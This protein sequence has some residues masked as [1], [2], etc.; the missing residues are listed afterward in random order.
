M[1]LDYPLTDCFFRAG[2]L[3]SPQVSVGSVSPTSFHPDVRGMMRDAT[4]KRY[5]HDLC[6][7]LRRRNSCHTDIQRSMLA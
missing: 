6:N 4:T 2:A 1:R 3:G 7:V 5:V